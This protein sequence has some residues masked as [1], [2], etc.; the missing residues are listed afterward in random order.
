MTFHNAEKTETRQWKC[1]TS[2]T[3]P[4]NHNGE[5]VDRSWLCFSPSQTCVYCFTCRLMCVD[6]TKYGHFLIR[7]EIYDWK[8]ALERL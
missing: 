7:K 8:H 3:R 2:L 5:I 4:Q 1:T 6:T